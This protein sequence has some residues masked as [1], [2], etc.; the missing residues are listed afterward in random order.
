MS[1][2]CFMRGSGR[3]TSPMSS[4]RGSFSSRPFVKHGMIASSVRSFSQSPFNQ[5]KKP[6][7]AVVAPGS[8]N[9]SK[10]TTPKSI[11]RS[12]PTPQSHPPSHFP[13]AV[14]IKDPPTL[15]PL[16][17]H[18]TVPGP[19]LTEVSSHPAVVSTYP[20][21]VTLDYKPDASTSDRVK[22]F[23][24]IASILASS[25]SP[26]LLYSAPSRTQFVITSVA[27][28]FYLV[29][30]SYT[31]GSTYADFYLQHSG[32][33]VVSAVGGVSSLFLLAIGGYLSFAHAKIIKSITAIPTTTSTSSRTTRMPI[34]RLEF[35]RS[36][37]YQKP[38]IDISPSDIVSDKPI[39]AFYK[40]LQARKSNEKRR[41][42]VAN[43]FFAAVRSLYRDF[44]KTWTRGSNFVYVR[45]QGQQG[46][47]KLDLA[48]ATVFDRGRVLEALVEVDVAPSLLQR[49]LR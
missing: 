10:K 32:G 7:S 8:S 5:A 20:K 1:S 39:G 37:G 38:S 28:S 35:C 40:E 15:R 46:N 42:N 19:K 13:A 18:T 24:I 21:N 6:R 2:V 17:N 29:T 11:P 16:S 9:R 44:V 31:V 14:D 30:S 36:F 47:W 49:L 22:E 48:D 33:I 4:C 23:R 3:F 45:I 26:T 12:S 41:S 27:S 34:L 43:R 25:A